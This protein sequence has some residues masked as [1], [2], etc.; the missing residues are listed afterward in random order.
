MFTN[1]KKKLH[2]LLA[3]ALSALLVINVVVPVQAKAQE[4]PNDPI[5]LAEYLEDTYSYAYGGLLD[6]RLLNEWVRTPDDHNL[7]VADLPGTDQLWKILANNNQTA[8]TS[9]I[10]LTALGLIYLNLGYL[11]LPLVGEDGLLEFVLGDAQVGALRE[12]AHAPSATQ[13]H[14][15]AG[16][17]SDS[18]GLELTHPGEGYNAKVDILSLLDL[19]G[20]NVI[21]ENVITEAALELGAV[22]AVAKAPDMS[23]VPEG[24]PPVCDTNLTAT[25]VGDP[26][27]DT[28][29]CSGYQVADAQLVLDAPLVGELV[30]DL[31]DRLNTILG[32]L[33][34]TV[35]SLLATDDSLLGVIY[36]IPLLGGLLGAIARP[37]VKVKIPLQN[38]TQ[39]LTGTPIA[40]S[41]GLVFIDLEKG[42]ITVDLKQLHEGDLNKLDPNTLLVDATQL[43]K[44]TS[45]LTSALTEGSATNPNGLNARIEEVLKGDDERTGL[46]ATEVTIGLEALIGLLRLDI[47]ATLGGL[48]NPDIEGT[49][50]RSLYESDP[51]NYYYRKGSLGL[52]PFTADIA[53][54]LLSQVGGVLETVLFGSGPESNG[55]LGSTVLGGLQTSVVS[56]LLNILNPVFLQILAPIAKIVINR[57]KQQPVAHGTVF[58]VSALELSLLDLGTDGEAIHLPL[59]TASVMAQ[60]TRLIDL[61]LDVAKIGD[62][63]GLHTGGYV[64]E[65]RCEA[66]DDWTLT[67]EGLSYDAL[68]VGSGFS[69]ADNQLHLTGATGGLADPL[70]VRPGAECTV[71]ANPALAIHNALRPTPTGNDSTAAR[72][73][74]T[75]FLDTDGTDVLVSGDTP[76]D[77]PTSMSSTGVTL[78]EN[79]VKVDATEVGAEWKTHSFTFLVPEDVDSHRVSI[80]HAYDIDR[81]DIEITKAVAGASVEDKFAFQYS[82]DDGT[83]W[84]NA[85]T[86]IGH[87]ETLTIKDIPVLNDSL[88]EDTTVMIREDLGTNPAGPLVSWKLNNADLTNTYGDGYATT[89]SFVSG[90]VPTVPTPK[91]QINITNSYAA[92]S[93]DK[94]IDG[95]LDGIGSTTLVPAGNTEMTIR[96]TV[97]NTGAVDLDTITIYDSSLINDQFALP[98]GITVDS[99]TGEVKGCTLTFN[100]EGVATCEFTV[101]L[102]E[103]FSHYEANEE[104]ATIVATATIDGREVTATATDK[105]GA[106]RLPDLVAM[107]PNT[108]ATTLVWVLGLGG[109]VALAALAN[110]IRSRRN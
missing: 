24:T 70:R 12:Y 86:T 9:N 100:E 63:R 104:E 17:V 78:D 35:N 13:A 30:T 22:S 88:E 4:T 101:T 18:G 84:I 96:Y 95:L 61:N 106:M 92:I 59:A 11:P 14:G 28:W 79:Q 36:D 39:A 58:T 38:V 91:Q 52:I 47:T 49:S 93:V 33:D 26:A 2:R 77:Q 105:H 69:F 81:R 107:L 27:D 82:L 99:T 37:T 94:H 60:R 110:Y 98:T 64:Y 3:M 53:V 66:E 48:L 57:Q 32:G 89:A 46:Y 90:P 75:Y 45:A 8:D 7:S 54:A 83:T 102:K 34:D 21:T 20:I 71:T 16:V 108:G 56:P 109:L 97:E 68:N 44:I 42:E 41:N 40:D 80:V 74:Y 1:L 85:D 10:D 73:P 19:G 29:V 55:L 87:E 72:T 23:D 31:Q 43:A 67:K 15:A 76:V 6:L 103:D 50:V 65:L 5:P 51:Y 62:G 25:P